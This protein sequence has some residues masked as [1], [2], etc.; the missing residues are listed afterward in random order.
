[1]W[2]FTTIGFF[3]VVQKKPSDAFLT[4]RARVASDLDNLRQQYMPSL[5]PTS[6][7]GGTDYP[8]RAT[9]SHADFGAGMAK[10]GEGI[11]YSNFKSEVARK[12]GSR[13]SEVYHKVWDVMFR[14]ES[15]G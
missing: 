1:M 13:R 5:S 7:K 9:I 2:L 10:I 15:E 12:M 4:V 3:S 6:S 14:L 11:K 8:Y